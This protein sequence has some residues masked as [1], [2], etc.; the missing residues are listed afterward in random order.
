M[1]QNS[2]GPCHIFS[3]DTFELVYSIIRL[4]FAIIILFF[5]I[6]ALLILIHKF[7]STENSDRLTLYETGFFYWLTACLAGTILEIYLFYGSI[8]VLAL[9]QKKVLHWSQFDIIFCELLYNLGGNLALILEAIT[10]IKGVLGIWKINLFRQR[11]PSLYSILAIWIISVIMAA[12]SV[13]AS[14]NYVWDNIYGWIYKVF[15]FVSVIIALIG[16]L[17]IFIYATLTFIRFN[18]TNRTKSTVVYLSDN[19]RKR[20]NSSKLRTKFQISMFFL[21]SLCCSCAI[22]LNIYIFIM[23]HYFNATWC[24]IW[25]VT[26]DGAPLFYTLTQGIMVLWIYSP[27]LFVCTRS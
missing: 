8:L 14:L 7:V 27:S 11:Y 9:V 18:C 3:E 6:T 20:I 4:C 15:E 13:L 1:A 10:A 22:F 16:I 24:V 19:A 5:N 25:Q 17:G 21:I 2:T 26:L 12:M 23:G